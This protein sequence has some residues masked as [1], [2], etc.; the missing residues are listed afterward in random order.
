MQNLTLNLIRAELKNYRAGKQEHA[1]VSAGSQGETQ[2]SRSFGD[3]TSSWLWTACCNGSVFQPARTHQS[4]S[5]SFALLWRAALSLALLQV[6]LAASGNNHMRFGV[7]SCRQ[8]KAVYHSRA[9]V[10]ITNRLYN[11]T[12]AVQRLVLFSRCSLQASFTRRTLTGIRHPFS[13]SPTTIGRVSN[14]A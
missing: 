11:H 1:R 4:G 6:Q 14:P 3:L 5:I 7:C 12:T 10:N 9:A 8:P 2:V 13:S